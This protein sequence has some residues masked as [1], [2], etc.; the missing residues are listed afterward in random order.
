M[1]TSLPCPWIHP[2][3]FQSQQV[4]CGT[5]CG[6]MSLVPWP[7]ASA[8]TTATR[9]C[10]DGTPSTAKMPVKNINSAVVTTLLLKTKTKKQKKE[11]TPEP[12]PHK[13]FAKAFCQS[14]FNIFFMAYLLLPGQSENKLVCAVQSLKSIHCRCLRLFFD[15]PKWREN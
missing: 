6:R 3:E 2:P 8:Q 7:V 11:Q 5:D 15:W 10:H 13:V 12:S 1:H 4:H 14:F 9:C